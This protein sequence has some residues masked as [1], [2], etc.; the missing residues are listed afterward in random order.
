MDVIASINSV[1]R[2]IIDDFHT[3][4]L[5]NP[6]CEHEVSGAILGL[7]LDD[8]IR[9]IYGNNGRKIALERYNPERILE[10]WSKILDT[11]LK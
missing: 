10:Q 4:F 11:L 2:S 1:A 7:I 9:K 8:N 5:V 3:G 6:S